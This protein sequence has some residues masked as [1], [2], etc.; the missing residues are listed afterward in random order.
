[1]SGDDGMS[2]C[3][4]ADDAVLPLSATIQALSPLDQIDIV[5]E[6]F[7]IAFSGKIKVE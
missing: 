7:L 1:M 3:G 4:R 2:V 5:N 6:L